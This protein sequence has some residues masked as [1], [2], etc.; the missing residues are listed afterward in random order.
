MG[1]DRL[2]ARILSDAGLELLPG[3]V[4]PREGR[5]WL[6]GC[7]GTRGV[8]RRLPVPIVPE[9]VL[10]QDV[11]WLHDFLTRLARLG[12][13]SP[14]PLRC[15]DGQSWMIADGLP[16]EVISF[17]PGRTVGWSAVPPMEE[18]GA[19]LGRYHA[20]VRQIEVTSQRLSALP[21][22]D[23]PAVLLSHRLDVVPPE[24]RA[25]IRQL[26]AQLAGD[27]D[28]T[29][30]LRR[31]RVV[32]HGD[33]TTD[34]VIAGGMPSRATGVIDFANAHAE[35]PLADIGYGLWRSGRPHERAV[36]LD[37]SRI[38]RFLRGYASVVPLSPDQASVIPVYLRGRGL[39]M[40]AKRVR[41]GRNET[42]MLAQV[43]WL[44]ANTGP[45]ADALAAAVL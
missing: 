23:V 40:I 33:F 42:G 24:E 18:V 14:R 36:Y 35:T 31:E 13:P 11:A 20:T 12:F 39:Q 21:L 6:V 3:K 45:V 38:R 17:L 30:H 2:P 15:F 1:D 27:L 22:A 37:F 26:A 19:L 7:Q 5:A 8:L 44:S 43:Q 41:A 10:A 16:W 28:G 4:R 34:N 29:G 32:I 9:T 25:V